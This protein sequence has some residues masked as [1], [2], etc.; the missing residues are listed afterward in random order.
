MDVKNAEKDRAVITDHL[1]DIHKS[2]MDTKLT[3]I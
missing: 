3:F 2:T 1:S